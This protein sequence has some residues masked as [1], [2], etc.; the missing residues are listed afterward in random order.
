M[1]ILLR[2]LPIL[3]VICEP[4]WPQNILK[5]Y[6]GIT[7]TFTSSN[8]SKGFYLAWLPIDALNRWHG[9][10]PAKQGIWVGG[11]KCVPKVPTSASASGKCVLQVLTQP[12]AFFHSYGTHLYRSAAAIHY[13]PLSTIHYQL[14]IINFHLSPFNYLLPNLGDIQHHRPTY[15]YVS[16]NVNI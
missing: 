9:T 12:F 7:A 10:R 3:G 4:F 8:S 1:N 14:S 16:K 13:Y 2:N 6:R 5:K 15:L 11:C